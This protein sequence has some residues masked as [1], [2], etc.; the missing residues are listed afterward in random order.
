MLSISY[1]LYI[2]HGYICTIYACLF[3]LGGELLY[4]FIV[5]PFHLFTTSFKPVYAGGTLGTANA[6]FLFITGENDVNVFSIS[7]F[8]KPSLSG[9]LY[10]YNHT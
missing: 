7:C 10:S 6:L 4:R 2:F 1:I 5:N 9:K 8:Y 3:S